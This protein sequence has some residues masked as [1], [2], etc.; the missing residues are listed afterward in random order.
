MRYPKK[1]CLGEI[2]LLLIK[3]VLWLLLAI[4][5][6]AAFEGGIIIFWGVFL[7]VVLR[8]VARIAHNMDLITEITYHNT[9]PGIIIFV[10]IL[11]LVLGFQQL[12]IAHRDEKYG[13]PTEEYRGNFHGYA[14]PF[15]ERLDVD[16]PSALPRLSSSSFLSGLHDGIGDIFYGSDRYNHM[17]VGTHWPQY[18]YAELVEGKCDIV[19]AFRPSE[20]WLRE[21]PMAGAPLKFTPIGRDALVFFV[22]KANPVSDLTV[23]QIRSIYSGK[24]TDWRDVGGR[25]ERIAAF[26]RAPESVSQDWLLWMMGEVPPMRAPKD[27]RLKRLDPQYRVT[28][29]VN[30]GNAIGFSVLRYARKM[31]ETADIKVVKVNGIHPD[32]KSIGDG[33]YPV[34]DDIF[35]V[36]TEKSHP[37][38]QV[39]I[40]WLLSP[41]GQRL[42]MANG[43][44][45]VGATE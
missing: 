5:F 17:V 10:L 2:F 23:E 4:F 25:V 18:A 33:S 11:F 15:E 12:Y 30:Y 19:I 27:F 41:Q 43:Y 38:A 31:I 32:A 14:A 35:A 1:G 20:K 29:Y 22:N 40:D 36:T 39:L 9:G 34:V 45:P 21:A 24:T 8:T 37:N 13:V 42:I 44:F 7:A 28:D 6:G 3:G 26:Q 16:K